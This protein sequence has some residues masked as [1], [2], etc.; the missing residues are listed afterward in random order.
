MT[1]ESM[2]K[3]RLEVHLK[4]KHSAYIDSDLDYFKSLKE[5]F[6]KR[7]TIKSLFKSQTDGLS[8]TKEVCYEIAKSGKNHTI[9]EDLIKPSISAF[10]KTVL[11]KDYKDVKAM[12]LSNN[13]VQRRIDEMSEDVEKQ[14][15]EKL[16]SRKFS[17]QLDEATL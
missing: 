7:S 12:P 6:A 3:G 13:T 1:N 10:L 15:V 4:A 16:K 8:R 14:L 17:L 5:K 2:K 11:E 9:G